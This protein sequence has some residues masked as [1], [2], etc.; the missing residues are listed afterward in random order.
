MNRV[1]L[2]CA[3]ADP[4]R[5]AEG[6]MP[7]PRPVKISHKKDGGRIDFMFLAPPY[8]AAGS[9]TEL[10][11]CI[12]YKAYYNLAM[13]PLL[14]YAT[15]VTV[16]TRGNNTK[17]IL[18]HYS[19][20]VFKH[21]FLPAAL[22]GWNT[23]PQSAVECPCIGIV[24]GQPPRCYILMLHQTVF[25]LHLVVVFVKC[26]FSLLFFFSAHHVLMACD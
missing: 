9:A 3:V 10:R 8:L 11:L 12:I 19:K 26:T 1:G 14:D 18:P 4:G 13:F 16:Q 22:R 15:P 7:P 2:I 5:G 6:T 23:L 20:N 24:Q 25:I 17:F 21:S